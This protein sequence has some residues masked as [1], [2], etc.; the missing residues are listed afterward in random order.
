MKFGRKRQAQQTAPEEV[1]EQTVPQTGAVGPFDADEINAAELV[2]AGEY[3]D[4]GSLLVPPVDGAELRMQVDE[5]SGAILS[6]MLLG[7]QGAM[8]MRA[9]AA[10]RTPGMWAEARGQI[11]DE[12]QRQGGTAEERD[13]AFGPELYI[14]QPVQ[15]E[16][17]EQL[18][19]PSRV[20]GHE[21]PRWFLRVTF[22]GAPA[23]DA[24]HAQ[25]WEDMLRQLAV[26]RGREALPPGEALPL[27][28]PD[29][30]EPID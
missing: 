16:D 5:E 27:T 21:G 24:E 29:N 1:V 13:G 25:M 15:T 30:A 22:L 26:R 23:V 20:I 4:L 10:P 7:E 2:A 9:F 14:E 12:V 3:I 17:G 11:A 18:V 6:V 19:Q 8:E 28:L